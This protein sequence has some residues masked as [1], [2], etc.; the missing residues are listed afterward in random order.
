MPREYALDSRKPRLRVTLAP[1]PTMMDDRI[2][3][4]GN[5]QGV[6]ER[7]RP[8]RKKAGTISISLPPPSKRARLPSSDTGAGL[9]AAAATGA[10]AAGASLTAG[11]AVLAPGMPLKAGAAVLLPIRR[12]VASWGA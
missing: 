1:S 3:I 5:T 10:G 9:T 4:I 6:N 7:P 11:A 8:S 12:A 2:G